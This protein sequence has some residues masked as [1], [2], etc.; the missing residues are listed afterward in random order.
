METLKFLHITTHY[1]PAHLGGDARFVEYLSNELVTAGHEV[2]VFQNPSAF[3]F[4]RKQ[5]VGDLGETT[6]AGV[7]R[8]L[9]SSPTS[10]MDILA[11]LSLGN[12][13][14]SRRMF[15]NTVR[16]VRPDVVHWHNTKGFFSTPLSSNSARMLF[17]AHDYYAV[18][19][20]YCLLRP[21][22]RVC[23]RPFLCQTCLLR[24]RKPPQLWRIGGRRVIRFPAGTVVISP[25]NF[26]AR[27]LEL[28][29][30]KV[31]SILRN[32]ALDSANRMKGVRTWQSLIYVGLLERQKGILTLVD[33]FIKSRKKQDFGMWILGEGTQ[34][35]W[36]EKR[37][38]EAGLNHRVRIPGFVPL[39]DAGHIFRESAAM[40][41]PSESYE[42]APLSVLEAFSAGLPVIG[43]D[44]GGL[45]EILGSESG[46]SVFPPGDIERLAEVLVDLW[47]QRGTLPDRGRLARGV[48]D[49]LFNPKVHLARYFEIISE[50]S[51]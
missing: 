10:R 25:S 43:S 9:P 39:Q 17:T 18:C 38:K 42:N 2:H 19:P 45:P 14:S 1:P 36:I 50:N 3:E 44:I 30:V 40:V 51:S 24:W 8:H 35:T 22:Y 47:N 12:T 11:A 46:S 6:D 20:R 41:V 32:F 16:E 37:I 21:G 5:R 48:Y 13:A 4:V 31:H 7:H 15:E 28:D 33:A 29:G 27:R 49:R 26:A 23:E 34:R